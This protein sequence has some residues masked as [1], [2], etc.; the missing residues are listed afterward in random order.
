LLLFLEQKLDARKQ[1]LFITSEDTSSGQASLFFR[2]KK[3]IDAKK[4]RVIYKI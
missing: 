3:S 4:T 1:E 2:A